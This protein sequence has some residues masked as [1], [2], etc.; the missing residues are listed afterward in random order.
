MKSRSE[1]ELPVKCEFR[2]VDEVFLSLCHQHPQK[3]GLRASPHGEPLS[4]AALHPIGGEPDIHCRDKR[5]ETCYH[6][7][8]AESAG[9]GGEEPEVKRK[10]DEFAARI[11]AAR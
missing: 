11:A 5:E 1:W 9:D 3:P 8:P 7:R 6:Y 4:D 2:E 10:A